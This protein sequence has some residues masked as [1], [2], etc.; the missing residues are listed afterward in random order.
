MSVVWSGVT[1]SGAV[2]PVQVD[3]LGRVIATTGEPPGP[4]VINYNGAS[5]WANFDGNGNNGRIDPRGAMNIA[6]ITKLTTGKYQVQF[7][8]PLGSADYSV[9][10]GY[11]NWASELTPAGFVLNTFRVTTGDPY[12]ISSNCFAVHSVNSLPPMGGTGTDAWAQVSFDGS[13]IL[14]SGFNIK[15]VERLSVGFFRLHFI[16][17]MPTENYA[18]FGQI[19]TGVNADRILVSNT[20]TTTYFDVNTVDT[21]DASVDMGFSVSVNATNA[22]LPVTYTREQIDAVINN[23]QKTGDILSTKDAVEMNGPVRLAGGK[24]GF[25]D[26]GQLYFTPGPGP[27]KYLVGVEDGQMKLKRIDSAY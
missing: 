4:P 1:E 18:A 25:T 14:L 2:V 8:N 23:W 22:T 13:P 3:E 9:V 12:D 10:A 26:E 15:S 24:A 7:Q 20:R 19:F 11:T 27:Q 6:R 21:Q 5:A 16:N 17:P